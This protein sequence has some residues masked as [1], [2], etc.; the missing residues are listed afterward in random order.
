LGKLEWEAPAGAEVEADTL[1]QAEV[2]DSHAAEELDEEESEAEPETDDLE[3]A[4]DASN[5]TSDHA[6]FRLASSRLL[7][8]ETQDYVPKLIAAAVIA[9]QPAH[10]GLTA[11][12]AAPFTYDSLVVTSTT[13]LDVIAR[14]AEVSVAE[15]RELN[16]QYL[17][18]ATPPRSVAVIRLPPGSGEQ[19]AERYAALPPNA[20]VQFMT[21]VVR[22]GERLARIAAR[23]HLPTNEILAAN[24]KVN[25]SRLKAGARL[26]I[27][28][29]AVP[30]ALA[31][32]AT[33]KASYG[34]RH[35]SLTH[36]VRSGETLIGI[37]RRYRV[38]LRAL[39]RANALPVQ[40]TLK[41][42]KRLR[43]PS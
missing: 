16:P 5:I 20:R 27:P 17:R 26:V 30:S 32:R 11:P 25:P 10:F 43:I 33:G 28:A 2:S 7:A 1:I 19:V 24:P 29:V 18:L 13:G 39:R 22:R 41:A 15:I 36:R 4:I 12:I 40:Y 6:F 38:T 3:A 14:L 37:A 35:R 31:I 42:G 8:V 21:H 23:Y 9:K 34:T